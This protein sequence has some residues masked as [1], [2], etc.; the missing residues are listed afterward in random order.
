M[1][2]RGIRGAT[3]AGEN[4]AEAILSATRELLL[5]MVRQNGVELDEIAAVVFT[6]TD[7][8]NAAFPAEASRALGWTSVPLLTAR[9]VDVPG[10]LPRCIRVL[11]LWNTPRSQEEVAHVYLREAEALRPDLTRGARRVRGPLPPESR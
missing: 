1:H 6:C 9:E 3:T 4:T 8:L 5:E 7:D 10:G 11:I 2:V